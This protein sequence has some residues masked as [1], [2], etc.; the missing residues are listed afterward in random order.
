MSACVGCKKGKRKCDGHVPCARCTSLG[1]ECLKVV[2]KKRGRKP[3]EAHSSIEDERE[4]EP[5]VKE[6]RPIESIVPVK[7]SQQVRE[8]FVVLLV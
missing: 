4:G 2:P 8:V 6:E 5:E 7:K 3:V 1:R